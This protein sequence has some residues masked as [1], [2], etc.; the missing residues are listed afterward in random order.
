MV[1]I[2]RG[3]HSHDTGREGTTV[4]MSV[5]LGAAVL[6]AVCRWGLCPRCPGVGRC[7]LGVNMSSASP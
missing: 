7:L 1:M 5:V 6:A 3:G 4:M 2:P